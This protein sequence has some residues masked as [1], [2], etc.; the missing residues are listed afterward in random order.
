MGVRDARVE[1][2]V[3]VVFLPELH[4]SALERLTLVLHLRS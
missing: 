3:T 4:S 2:Q 1:G